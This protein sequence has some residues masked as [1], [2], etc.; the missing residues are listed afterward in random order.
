MPVRD[1]RLWTYGGLTG[2][3]WNRQARHFKALGKVDVRRLLGD[4]SVWAV[5]VFAPDWLA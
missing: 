1:V 4:C 5:D 2:C 3:R